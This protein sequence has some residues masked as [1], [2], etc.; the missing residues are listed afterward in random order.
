M[1]N[2][3]IELIA[4][5]S[6]RH[7][8]SFSV[9]KT[10][11]AQPQECSSSILL[12]CLCAVSMEIY[13]VCEQLT[14]VSVAYTLHFCSCDVEWNQ[15]VVDEGDKL[16]I[17]VKGKVFVWSDAIWILILVYIVLFGQYVYYYFLW[18]GFGQYLYYN[19]LYLLPVNSF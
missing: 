11:C 12:L 16:Y 10:G 5:L 18:H 8:S 14:V 3:W 4:I 17:D 13:N 19:S 15:G 2:E 9:L 7:W 6:A 1:L